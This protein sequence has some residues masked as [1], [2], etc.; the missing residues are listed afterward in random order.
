MGGE[1][2]SRGLPP[3]TRLRGTRRGTSKGKGDAGAGI[4][5]DGRNRK[6]GNGSGQHYEYSNR[7]RYKEG[8]E[9]IFLKMTLLEP[10]W[11]PLMA[12]TIICNPYAILKAFE[13]DGIG[14]ES[15]C[16]L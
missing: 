10:F 9:K 13:G 8:F 7:P 3:A 5:F 2:P 1:P 16:V 14:V 4:L 15:F 11:E 12:D 6:G